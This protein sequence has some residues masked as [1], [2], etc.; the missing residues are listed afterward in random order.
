MEVLIPNKRNKYG[1]KFGFVRFRK[2]Q[3]PEGLETRLDNIILGEN[4]LHLNLPKFNRDLM[5]VRAAN[6]GREEQHKEFQRHGD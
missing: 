6:D 2:L 4:K 1:K 3:N 5:P